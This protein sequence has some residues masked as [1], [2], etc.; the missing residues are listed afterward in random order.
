MKSYQCPNTTELIITTYSE[1]TFLEM[2]NLF[3]WTHSQILTRLLTHTHAYTV[4]HV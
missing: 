2:I 4:T 1:G 3:Q